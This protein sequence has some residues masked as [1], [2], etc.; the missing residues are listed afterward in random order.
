[1]TVTTM[2]ENT[3]ITM[4]PELSESIVKRNDSMVEAFEHHYKL[5]KEETTLTWASK[6]GLV[7]FIDRFLI[8]SSTCRLVNS[9]DQYLSPV[10]QKKIV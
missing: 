4:I 1:M 3:I 10:E 9:T 6:S 8:S 5:R 7:K 2:S